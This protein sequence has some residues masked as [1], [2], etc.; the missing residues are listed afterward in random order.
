[1]QVCFLVQSFHLSVVLKDF[2]L[3]GYALL[4]SLRKSKGLYEIESEFPFLIYPLN[5]FHRFKHSL[6][7]LF[8]NVID[9]M[10]SQFSI[11]V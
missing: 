1:M 5:D 9:F 4:L 3:A 8:A 6:K 2:I 11:D 7:F 10:H